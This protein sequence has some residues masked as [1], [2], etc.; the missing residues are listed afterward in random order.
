M[1]YGLFMAMGSV[2][3]EPDAIT[4]TTRRGRCRRGLSSGSRWADA[5]DPGLNKDILASTANLDLS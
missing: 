1:T 3:P 2:V 5:E 4:D